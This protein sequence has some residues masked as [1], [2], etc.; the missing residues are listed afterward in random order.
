[1][2]L[3]VQLLVKSFLLFQ[4]VCKVDPLCYVN[5]DV[6]TGKNG[7]NGIFPAPVTHVENVSTFVNK[8]REVDCPRFTSFDA[9]STADPDPINVLKYYDRE[10]D[11]HFFLLAMLEK[12]VVVFVSFLFMTFVFNF[13]MIFIFSPILTFRFGLFIANSIST[14]YRYC[15]CFTYIDI[16]YM[17]YYNF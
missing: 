4:R 12:N 13:R 7:K 9:S 10:K 6:S 11:Q 2:F 1:M 17:I 5:V 16:A 15:Y 14:F 8:S 3:L